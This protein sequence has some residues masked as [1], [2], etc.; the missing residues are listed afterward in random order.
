MGRLSDKFKKANDAIAGFE[1][2]VEKDVDGVIERVGELHA[3]REQVKLQKHMQ[4]DTHMTDL[5]EFAADLDEE[6]RGNGAPLVGSEDG[7]KPG[8]VGME[9][10][11]LASNAWDGDAYQG[12]NPNKS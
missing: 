8:P 5:H 11:R 6:M 12:T 4:L 7:A 3:K 9:P 2:A 1:V 10:G